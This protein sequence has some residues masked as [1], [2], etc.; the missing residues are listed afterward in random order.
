M[1]SNRNLLIIGGLAI[2]GLVAYFIL[3]KGTGQSP[4][5]ANPTNVQVP[6]SIT[7][8]STFN[9]TPNLST[10]GTGSG[11]FT[12]QQTYSPYYSSSNTWTNTTTQTTTSN[13]Q[14]SLKIG[15]F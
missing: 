5:N 4:S 12:V 13:P 3:G 6:T 8:A 2:A 15:L 9:S 14:S 10:G 1:A 11:S 7:P